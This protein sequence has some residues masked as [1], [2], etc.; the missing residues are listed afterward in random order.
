MGNQMIH[1]IKRPAPMMR[2]G[3]KPLFVM[4]SSLLANR[5]MLKTAAENRL[6]APAKLKLQ[7]DKANCARSVLK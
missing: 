3:A 6:K 4:P 7:L 1:V 5:I 2:K